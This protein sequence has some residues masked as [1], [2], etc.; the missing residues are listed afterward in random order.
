MGK[1]EEM[2]KG[3]EVCDMSVPQHR[4]S[5]ETFVQFPKLTFVIFVKAA[6]EEAVML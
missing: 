3:R 6:T 1:N 4:A 5:T 2:L